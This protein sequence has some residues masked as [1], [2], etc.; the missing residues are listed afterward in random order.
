[1]IGASSTNG[2]GPPDAS[3]HPPA[4]REGFVKLPPEAGQSG[5]AGKS[6]WLAELATH[7]PGYG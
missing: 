7:C 5:S 6:A 2:I 3:A 4:V 1:M